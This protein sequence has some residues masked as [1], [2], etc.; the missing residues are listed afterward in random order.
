MTDEHQIG[1]DA[2][3]TVNINRMR[4]KN[5]P[6]A[7]GCGQI[8]ERLAMPTENRLGRIGGERADWRKHREEEDIS[9]DPVHY[10]NEEIA[11]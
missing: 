7:F 5:N 1:R 3:S 2:L 9:H 8:E 6:G 11:A 10:L 4:I